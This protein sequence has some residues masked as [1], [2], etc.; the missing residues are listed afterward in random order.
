[1]RFRNFQKFLRQGSHPLV[2]RHEFPRPALDF[3]GT[4]GVRALPSCCSH[5]RRCEARPK[6]PYASSLAELRGISDANRI[7]RVHFCTGGL[8]R[9]RPRPCHGLV[10]RGFRPS[11][12]RSVRAKPRPASSTMRSSA[13]CPVLVPGC[14]RY[15]MADLKGCSE[16]NRS[17]RVDFCTGRFC[18][19][20]PRPCNSVVGRGF[21]LATSRSGRAARCR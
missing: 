11:T 15:P 20:R 19:G 17:C 16:A 3:K 14:V 13:Q 1:M 7:Y 5:R 6:A 10:G 2:G 18:C 8:G 21:P 9:G 4:R 12:R